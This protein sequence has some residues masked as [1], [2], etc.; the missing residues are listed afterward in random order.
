MS[1]PLTST[2]LAALT[3]SARRRCTDV[4]AN[5]EAATVDVCLAG[6]VAALHLY[7]TSGRIVVIV[8]VDEIQKLRGP[9]D[10]NGVNF[11]LRNA[12]ADLVAADAAVIPPKRRP[13]GEAVEIYKQLWEQL[14]AKPHPRIAPMAIAAGVTQ[15]AFA[16]WISNTHPG[17][18][19]RLRA[20]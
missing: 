15:N 8:P 13:V 6:N 7:T 19:K 10:S 1:A 11:P 18:L 14:L 2:H 9:R 20:S 16:C 4:V 17:E 12:S 3:P 5:H